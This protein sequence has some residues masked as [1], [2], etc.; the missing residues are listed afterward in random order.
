VRSEVIT[1]LV[2]RLA[3]VPA[4]VWPNIRVVEVEVTAIRRPVD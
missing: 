1:Q 3:V 2:F 4:L